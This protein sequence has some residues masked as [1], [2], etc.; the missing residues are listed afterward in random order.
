MET[1]QAT[2]SPPIEQTHHELEAL[3]L[4]LSWVSRR[5][6]EQELDVYGL[7]VPQYM[8]L[9]CIQDHQSGCNM[10]ELADSAF[11][12]SA[13]MTGIIDRL[14]ERGLVTRNRDMRD[15]RAQRVTLT[16]AGR[17]MMQTVDSGRNSLFI[18]FLAT[19]NAQEREKLI[20]TAQHFLDVI[21]KDLR[22]AGEE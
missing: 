7:T 3:L 9:H 4:R 17:G 13:T 15:R 2:L 21:E 11:Q 8:A 18:Q 6:L 19:F 5:R 22:A 10:T 14:A 12:V 1:N 16:P 20:N